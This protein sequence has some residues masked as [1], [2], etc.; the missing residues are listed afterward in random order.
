MGIFHRFFVM[1]ADWCIYVTD[2]G[3]ESHFH[4]IF[5][6]AEQCGWHRPPVTR[7][8]HMGFGVVLGADGKKFKT[9]SGET[10]KLK[11]ALDETTEHAMVEIQ[12]RVAGQKEAG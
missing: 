7:C 3:Q 2:L 8:D 5:D 1:R 4:M 10:V 12:K 6:A 9:R 11:D